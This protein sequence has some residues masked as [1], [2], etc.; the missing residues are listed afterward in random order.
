[1]V[2]SGCTVSCTSP[3]ILVHEVLQDAGCNKSMYM[4]YDRDLVWSLFE[5]STM[6]YALKYG[7]TLLQR[8]TL[9]FSVTLDELY[10]TLSRLGTS[11]ALSFAV[12]MGWE[13]LRRDSVGFL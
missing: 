7:L 10:V 5:S 2:T 6:F 3:Y 8:L 1:M 9:K 12:F 4:H 13:C 11:V